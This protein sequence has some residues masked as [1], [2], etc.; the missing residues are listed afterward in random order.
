MEFQKSL[1]LWL[2]RSSEAKAKKG[3]VSPPDPPSKWE[4]AVLQWLHLITPKQLQTC[5]VKAKGPSH[6][7]RPQGQTL[8]CEE[9]T[10]RLA[11]LHATHSS[12]LRHKAPSAAQRSC[13]LIKFSR[14]NCRVAGENQVC[15]Y[16][17]TDNEMSRSLCSANWD[18]RERGM[19]V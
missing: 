15:K 8:Q 5:R 11:A 10:G 6:I 12:L 7:A 1:S 16:D 4:G 19:S 14:W 2:P 3:A 13:C 17:R 9:A 18:F